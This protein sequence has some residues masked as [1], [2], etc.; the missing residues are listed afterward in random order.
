MGPQIS[1]Y[2]REGESVIRP[3]CLHVD[4]WRLLTSYHKV[5]ASA[6]PPAIYQ[7]TIL[8]REETALWGAFCFLSVTPRLPRPFTLSPVYHFLNCFGGGL[9]TSM[10]LRCFCTTIIFLTFISPP[11]LLVFFLLLLLCQYRAVFGLSELFPR[12]LIGYWI[13]SFFFN[14]VFWSWQHVSSVCLCT[15]IS[16]PVILCLLKPSK[17]I[18]A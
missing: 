12:A 9:S 4:Q 18:L 14:Q 11:F 7:P 16:H 6:L 10:L 15:I 17:M 5:I 2:Q 8:R 13:L 1:L 3:A